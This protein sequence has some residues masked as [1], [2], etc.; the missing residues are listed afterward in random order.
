METLKR[1][2]E[3]NLIQ[4]YDFDWCV[5]VASVR[6]LTEEVERPELIDIPTLYLIVNKMYM[7]KSAVVAQCNGEYVGALGGLLH[8][9]LL[10]PNIATLSEL[11]WFVLP[12]YRKTRVGAML[13]K[14]YDEIAAET[15]A[16][17]ATFSLLN[18]SA[19]NYKSLEKKGFKI[20]EQGFRKVYKEF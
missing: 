12:E 14:S 5:H 16:H 15:P 2:Y 3:V 13:L 17:D 20:E 9:N 7:D 1:N 19:V 8:P 11:M 10:N 4:P 6:M 18:R